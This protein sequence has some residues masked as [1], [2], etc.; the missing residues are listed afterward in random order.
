MKATS[1]KFDNIGS[2]K[3]VKAMG[4]YDDGST[5][6]ISDKVVWKFSDPGSAHYSGGKITLDAKK[7][8]TLTLTYDG[9]STTIE[10][11]GV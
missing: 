5:K 8:Q 10:I 3:S 4:H 11:T 1:L 9:V 2:S 7:D 6:D